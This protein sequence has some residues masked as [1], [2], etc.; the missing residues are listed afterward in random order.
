MGLAKGR[1]G[2]V[3]GLIVCGMPLAVLGYARHQK[4]AAE[5][6]AADPQ[7]GPKPGR[8]L[9]TLAIQ[10]AFDQQAF[11]PVSLEGLTLLEPVADRLGPET[12]WRFPFTYWARSPL[13]LTTFHRGSFWV[14]DGRVLREQWG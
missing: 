14:K 9:M 6:S 11:D 5:R 12:C 10:A 3:W 13:G 1:K 8:Q 2:F 7:P 4:L